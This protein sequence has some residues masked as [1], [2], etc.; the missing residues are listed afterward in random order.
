MALNMR[1]VA[2][3]AGVSHG[4]VSNVLNDLPTV[5]PEIRQRVLDAISETGYVRNENARQLKVGRSRILGLIVLDTGNPFY[6]DL[7]RGAEDESRPAGLAVMMCNSDNDPARE[8]AYLSIL[9]EQRAQGIIFASGEMTRDLSRRLAEMRARGTSIVV[10]G[11]EEKIAADSCTVTG[12]DVEGARLAAE[13]LLALG[14]SEIAFINGPRSLEVCRLR[15]AGF[16]EAINGFTPNPV[17]LTYFERPALT[18]AEGRAAAAE[19]LNSTRPPSAVFCANDLLALG[20][21][22]YAVEND[23]P[24]P[25]QLAIVGYDDISFAAGAAIPLTSV[26]QS[27]DQLGHAAAELLLEEI[28][29]AAQHKHKQV[30]FS[31]ALIARRSTT[32]R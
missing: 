21:L 3:R 12:D 2:R 11:G 31:P 13:H 22:Q 7:A 19:L 27:G 5:R 20:V 26:R 16:T 1:D 23:I 30:V 4:T 29:D 28:N 32:G 24:V 6:N 17:D 25:E 14:H 9:E 8:T 18:I 15:H 10:I